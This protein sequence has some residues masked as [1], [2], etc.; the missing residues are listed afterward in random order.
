MPELLE[1]AA[2]SHSPV[3]AKDLVASGRIDAAVIRAQ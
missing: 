1:R 2:Y 3:T